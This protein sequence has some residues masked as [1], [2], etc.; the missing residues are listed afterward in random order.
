MIAV[1]K[2]EGF[3]ERNTETPLSVVSSIF[4]PVAKNGSSA[5]AEIKYRG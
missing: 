2:G 3:P 4:L 5:M 1:H